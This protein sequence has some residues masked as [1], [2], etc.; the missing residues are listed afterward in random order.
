MAD[1]ETVIRTVIATL[2]QRRGLTDVEMT[3]ETSLSED[4]GLDSLELAE[5]SATLEDEVGRDPYT[6]GVAPRTLGELIGFYDA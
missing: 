5:L 1:V 4:L 6:E 2:L 3:G